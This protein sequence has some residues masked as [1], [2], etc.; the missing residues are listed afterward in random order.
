MF[1]HS[2]GDRLLWED[3]YILLYTVTC[4]TLLVCTVCTVCELDSDCTV[5]LYICTV[6]CGA[7]YISINGA[8]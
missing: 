6:V 2:P 4:F 5:L 1:E 8:G 3:G 7:M